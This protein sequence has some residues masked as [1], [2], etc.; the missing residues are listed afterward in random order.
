MVTDSQ[1]RS[2]A[3]SFFAQQL[4]KAINK[5]LAF[6]PGTRKALSIHDGKTI[7]LCANRPNVSLTLEIGAGEVHVYH[8]WE[9]TPTVKVSGPLISILFQLGLDKSPGELIA[10]GVRV[11]GDQAFAQELSS[12][13]RDN[14]I[15]LEEPLSQWVGDVTAHQIGQTA[16]SAFSWLKKTAT[17]L[18]DDGS[19]YLREESQQVVEKKDLDV[20]CQQVDQT[21]NDFDRLEVRVKLLQ[22]GQHR[23][24]SAQPN[25]SDN[26]FDPQP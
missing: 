17:S 18:L 26:P 19:H 1:Q 9:G 2:L 12:I 5:A 20:F 13:F 16:R 11:E 21:R 4:E 6:A 7:N 10:S 8:Y 14:D 15:D 25:N 22:A 23:E 24:P 3:P